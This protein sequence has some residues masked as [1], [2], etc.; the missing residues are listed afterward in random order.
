MRFLYIYYENQAP[1]K[2]MQTHYVS[3][4]NHLTENCKPEINGWGRTSSPSFFEQMNSTYLM[5]MIRVLFFFP[6]FSFSNNA[7]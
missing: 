5:I 2:S 6:N 4:Y 7:E 3:S 1:R